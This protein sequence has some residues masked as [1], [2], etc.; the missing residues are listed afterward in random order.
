MNDCY[1]VAVTLD[2]G[3][4]V[5]IMGILEKGRGSVLPSG[6]SW[7]HEGYWYRPASSEVI[8][9]EISR[10]FAGKTVVSYRRIER[11]EIPIDRA[12]RNALV[13]DGEKLIHDM[14]KAREVH[15]DKL[16]RERAS[17]MEALDIELI[18]AL[19]AGKPVKD[20]EAKKQALRDMPTMLAPKLAACK[21]IN[22][23]KGVTL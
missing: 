16:R 4:P 5:A 14:S 17:K 11:G 12:Y 1:F 22:E 9:E 20:I 23:L 10:A 8:F 13:D 3:S 6:A 2:D 21:T 15:L 18:R 7:V 19:G